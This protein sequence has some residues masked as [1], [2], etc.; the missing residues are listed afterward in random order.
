[1]IMNT[2]G[3]WESYNCY[4]GATISHAVCQRDGKL[5]PPPHP[6]IGFANVMFIWVTKWASPIEI[7][8][9]S[10]EEFWKKMY[11]EWV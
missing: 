10:V 9:P 11:Q 1:M 6:T 2:A 8:T 3:Q 7:H 4:D 5:L